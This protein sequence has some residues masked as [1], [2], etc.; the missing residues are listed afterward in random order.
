MGEP[1][2]PKVAIVC[3]DEL[4]NDLRAHYERTGHRTLRKVDAR[5]HSRVSLLAA[6]RRRAQVPSSPNTFSVVR[7]SRRRMEPSTRTLGL[8]TSFRLG[9]E[10]GKALRAPIIYLLKESTP[11]QGF[12][13][14]A[15]FLKVRAHLPA[16]LRVAVTVMYTFGWRLDEVMGL[17]L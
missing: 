9:L 2:F 4:L 1:V 6:E 17:R 3:A 8:G 11:S 13:E 7:Q 16:D 12:F 5:L 15:D 14:D 10:H